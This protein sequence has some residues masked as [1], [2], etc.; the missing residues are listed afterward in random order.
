MDQLIQL[1]FRIL[2]LPIA[3]LIGWTTE[4]NHLRSLDEREQANRGMIVTNVKRVA[5]PQTVTGA[6]LVI[7]HVVIATDYWKS[8]VSR[9]RNL[10]GGEA[11]SA[12]TLML[13]ARRE[14]MVRMLDHARA[15]GAREVWNV[16]FEFCNISMMNGQTGAMQVEI[17]AY[18]T[19]VVREPQTSQPAPTQPARAQVPVR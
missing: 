17:L 4:R 1:L 15:F 14:A 13:R 9:L 16:R 3:F 6:T 7:G 2:A 19:A 8:F 10:V 18:G 11:K 5:R 12:R